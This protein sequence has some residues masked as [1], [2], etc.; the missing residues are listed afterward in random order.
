MPVHG[1]VHTSDPH[2]FV[3]WFGDRAR[4]EDGGQQQH[5]CTRGGDNR[6]PSRGPR[7]PGIGSALSMRG[8]PR[9]ILHQYPPRAPTIAGTLAPPCRPAPGLARLRS[10]AAA[11][12]P[13]RRPWPARCAVSELALPGPSRV[14]HPPQATPR[15]AGCWPQGF[16]NLLG[17]GGAGPADVSLHPT[18]GAPEMR[19]ASATVPRVAA[20]TPGTRRSAQPAATVCSGVR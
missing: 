18:G 13:P 19:V 4:H 12:A 3:L 17:C 16:Q 6:R 10:R 15:R 14:H 8:M 9:V 11:A 7:H 2:R 20:T 5:T 1:W